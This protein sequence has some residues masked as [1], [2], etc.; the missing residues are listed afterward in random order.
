M[1]RLAEDIARRALLYDPTVLHDQ[2]SIRQVVDHAEYA[3]LVLLIDYIVNED[4][5][6][7]QAMF[8]QAI[9]FAQKFG[10]EIQEQEDS[11]D[12]DHQLH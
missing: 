3:S 2:D 1:F 9:Q 10:I 5:N 7:T 8:A 4:A 6:M 12:D 11:A